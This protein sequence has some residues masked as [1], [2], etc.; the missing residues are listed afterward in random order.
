[1]VRAGTDRQIP[2]SL[3]TQPFWQI[4]AESPTGSPSSMISRPVYLRRI[5]NRFANLSDPVDNGR[6]EF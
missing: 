2:E 6:E 1:M 5:R 4:E 3:E